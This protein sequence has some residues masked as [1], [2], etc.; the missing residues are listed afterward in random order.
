[1][2]SLAPRPAEQQPD[3]APAMPDDVRLI[4]MIRNAV[5]ALNQANITGNYTVLREMGTAN[6]QMSNTSARLAEV[7]A[8]L[9]SRKL[10]LSP[11]MAFN[12]K[13][14]SAP[15]FQEGQVLR[16]TGYFPTAPEQVQFDLAFQRAGEQWLLAGI[17]LNVAPLGDGAQA[18]ASPG[19]QLAQN[20]IEA[21]QA[22]SGRPGE[23]KPVRIDLAQPAPAAGKPALP[24]KPAA[25]KKP[26][27]R[28]QKTAAASEPAAT[29]PVAG[30]SA[31]PAQAPAQTETA[32]PEAKPTE[33]AP[34][35]GDGWNPFG[36]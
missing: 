2:L 1:M 29:A 19:S 18:S 16:L 10:D 5:V 33:K 17:S 13:L 34:A 32:A 22:A 31:Q 4:L 15:A 11:V 35:F 26:K 9:R 36:H 25:S 8:T 21:S 12:P 7:F 6:F 24:K 28:A 14:T 23:A 20:A 27:T 30:S 3:A